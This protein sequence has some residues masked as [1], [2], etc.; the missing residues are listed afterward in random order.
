MFGILF[1]SMLIFFI[2][3]VPIAFALGV[4][5]LCAMMYLGNLPLVVVP[6]RMFVALDSWVVIAIPLF[7]L[8][9][10][11]MSKGGM[12]KRI[13]DFFNE[14]FS[15][16]KGGL[17]IIS[18]AASMVFAGV[19]GSS[20]ADT[21]A[22]GSIVLPA[23]KE[24][25]YNMKWATALQSA[26]GSI[27]PVIPPSLLMILIG[28]QTETSVAKL[29]LGGFVPGVLIGIGLMFISYLHALRGGK[30]Y[31]PVNKSKRFNL[32][33]FLKAGIVALPGLGLPFIIIFGIIGG[34][35]TA[36]EAAVVAV[37]YG[38]IVGLFV[39]K[40]LTIKDLPNILV[41]SA[42]LACVIMLIVSVASLFGW[43]LSVN[44]LHVIMSKF[45]V[46]NI[47]NKFQFLIFL[48]VFLIIVGM[49]M[50]S[51]SAIIILVPVFFPVAQSYGIDPI[52]FGVIVCVNLAIGYIT[53]PYGATL[54]VACG[55]TGKTVREVT[56]HIL[57]MFLV[58][59][60]VL[61]IVTYLPQSFMW[62]P[63]MLK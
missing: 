56:P 41:E 16:I 23:M 60:F 34:I 19:S 46:E 22:I 44:Q 3:G 63:N 12:S 49:F 20:T 6:Q 39:Y 61:M 17:A 21:A 30:E 38:L 7:M 35:F 24:S 59:F 50:E 26:A 25:G 5:T 42:E 47:G 33:S 27:G 1:I 4:S 51:F 40:E 52:H 37:V 45:M 11:L 58:M 10:N 8:A 14:I 28:F 18:V 54:Y 48:N 53:P 62:I 31:L 15:F 2:T 57:P 36:T 9:G 55:L 13:V 43:F 32:K 29:F